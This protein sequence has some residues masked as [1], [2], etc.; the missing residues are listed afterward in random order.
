MTYVPPATS[1]SLD[2]RK[3]NKRKGDMGILARLLHRHK[4]AYTKHMP[5]EPQ[6]EKL[7]SVKEA[8][9]LLGVGRQRIYD[10]IDADR[11][12]FRKIGRDI[13]ISETDLRHIRPGKTKTGRP[14]KALE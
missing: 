12:D 2:A 8:A 3:R 1:I 7:Y 9:E 14:K 4:S 5:I 13:F 11:L 6:Q 10:L